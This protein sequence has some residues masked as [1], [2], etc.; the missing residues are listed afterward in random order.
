[1]KKLIRVSVRVFVEHLLRQGNLSSVF[2]LSSRTSGYSGMRAHQK[3]QKSRPDSYHS[4]VPVFYRIDNKS[5]TLDI[6]GRIDGVYRQNGSVVI[7]EIKT[8]R[9]DLDNFIAEQNSLHWTQVKTYAAM[10]SLENNIDNIQA[11]LTYCQLETGEIK[12]FFQEVSNEKLYLFFLDLVSQYLDWMER[13][14]SW[15]SARN[16][17]I[18]NANFPFSSFRLGQLQ[19]VEDVSHTIQHQEQMIIQAPTGTGKTIAALF[20]AVKAL[21]QGHVDKI[22]YLTARTTGRVITEKTLMELNTK[23]LQIKFVTITAKD[24]ICFNPDKNCTSEEC[25]YA[26]GY[27]DRLAEARESLFRQD[28]FTRETILEIAE[29]YEICPF[30]FSLDLSLWVDC[31]ICD[32]NYAF[33]PRVYLRRFFLENSINCTFLIDEAH[34]L[35]DRSREMFSARITKGSFLELR[36]KLDN[37]KSEI[38]TLIGEI[39]NTLLERKQALGDEVYAWD[40]DCPEDLLSLL[41]RLV[42]SLERKVTAN[43]QSPLNQILLDYYFEVNWFCKVADMYD[44]NYVTCLEQKGRDLTVKLFCVDPSAHLST[45]L[46]R[47]NSAVLFSATITPMSYFAQILGCREDVQKRILPSPFPPENL[48]LLASKSVSTLYRHR[49]HTKN[50]LAKTI[51]SLVEAKKGNYLVFFP[52]YAYMDMV[53]PLY[54][55][56]FPHHTMLVQIQG[57]S[58]D[59]RLQFLEHFSHENSKT[60]VGFVVMGGI[61]GEGIDL[62][63]DRLSGAVVV[64]VG[65]PALSLERELIRVHFEEKQ[66]PGFNYSYL[67]PG[68]NRVF[69]AAGR[70]I[71]SEEDRGAIL[72]VDTRYSLP[73]YASLFPSDWQV[74]FVRDEKQMG[75]ILDKFWTGKSG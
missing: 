15:Q 10:Y 26:K 58:E 74:R 24:K 70:V 28:E 14:E 36:R 34:N 71:R 33:D 62:M 68:M 8:T 45:A 49:T 2:D 17:V 41:R 75:H 18:L 7:E 1:M 3:I 53:I 66:M 20:P 46:E 5:L 12:T 48:C 43:P 54:E 39:N 59:E 55:Q 69:Q 11:Q 32:V 25:P 52:S 56:L 4:E 63:G 9:R 42:L 6:Q 23:G 19:M 38:Y 40:K 37:K 29:F 31:V 35:V 27:Y 73:Q 65:L 21:A 61:F 51:G 50:D 57:M 22:F 30:E 16:E 47:T 44:E 64:G 60:L 72:L 13:I 67:Y